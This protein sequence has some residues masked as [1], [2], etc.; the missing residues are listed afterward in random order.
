MH[1]LLFKNRFHT[2]GFVAFV[3]FGVWLLIGENG[4]GGA[5][6]RMAAQIEARAKGK[7]AS[8]PVKDGGTSEIVRPTPVNNA[9]EAPAAMPVAPAVIPSP[10]EM[11]PPEDLIDDARGFEP[12]GQSTDP[13]MDGSAA[14]AAESDA[15]DE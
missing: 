14:E 12:R 8:S 9:F 15:G 1:E 2:L 4:D 6:T 3:L 7:A 10:V 11:A 13:L 5:L